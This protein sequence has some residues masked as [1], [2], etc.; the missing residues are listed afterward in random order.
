MKKFISCFRKEVG[1]EALCV[2]FN[3]SLH[4][5]D[6]EEQTY[7]CRQNNP[8]ICDSNGIEGIC[9]FA[10]EDGICKHPSKA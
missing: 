2:A 9:A 8:D 3:A 5:Y 10:S 1:M 6:S 4:E 7:G